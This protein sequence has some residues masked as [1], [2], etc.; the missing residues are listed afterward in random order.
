MNNGFDDML[1]GIYQGELRN[2]NI[3]IFKNRPLF[4]LWIFLEVKG[5]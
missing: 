4:I 5:T 2:K 1:K 3:K